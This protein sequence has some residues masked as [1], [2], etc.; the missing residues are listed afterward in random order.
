MYKSFESCE[1]RH[2]VNSAILTQGINRSQVITYTLIEKG[3]EIVG[4]K[5]YSTA[6]VFDHKTEVGVSASYILDADEAA[7][8]RDWWLWG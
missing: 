2:I 8:F 3:D 6:I 7:K 1:F 4:M 5:L